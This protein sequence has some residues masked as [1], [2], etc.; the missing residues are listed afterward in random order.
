MVMALVF[1][2]NHFISLNPPPPHFISLNP[3]GFIIPLANGRELQHQMEVSLVE[4]DRVP[5]LSVTV[6]TTP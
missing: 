1:E 6:Q 5:I 3:P 4:F 2:V